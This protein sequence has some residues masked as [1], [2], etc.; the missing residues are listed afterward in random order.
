MKL[1]LYS[2]LFLTILSGSNCKKSSTT[3]DQ[4]P[5]ETTTGAMTFGCKV[6]G[7]VF[8]PKDGKGKP[9]LYVQYVY[10]GNGPGGGWFL[11]IPA[12]DWT[13][14]SPNGVNIET[15]SLLVVQGQTYPFKNAKGFPRT[16]YDNGKLYPKL[17]SDSGE[18]KITK[19]DPTTHILSGIFFFVGT[20]SSG[21]KIN[22]TDG[23]FDIKY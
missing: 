6:D 13:Q 20:N 18:L 23:R 11:N 1:L 16:F 10:L 22:V 8:V 19:F 15:D 9:G 2:L 4:L 21:T 12:T 17:D 3:E 14:D 7:K 5:P